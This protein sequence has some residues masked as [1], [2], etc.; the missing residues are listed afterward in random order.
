MLSIIKSL[1]RWQWYNAHSM[2]ILL[3]KL[4]KLLTYILVGTYTVK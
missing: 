2:M 1:E 3:V 4:Q